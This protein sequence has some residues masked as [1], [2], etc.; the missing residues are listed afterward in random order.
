[1]IWD[2]GFNIS[3][4]GG[5]EGQGVGSISIISITWAMAATKRPVPPC[6][7]RRSEQILYLIK[8]KK[9]RNF[10]PPQPFAYG[11]VI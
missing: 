6:Q 1:M 9:R 2:W 7:I 4:V 3:G 8:F 11:K 5:I 10:Y